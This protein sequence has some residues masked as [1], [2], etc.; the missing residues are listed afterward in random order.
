MSN[1]RTAVI[2]RVEI[3]LIQNGIFLCFKTQSQLLMPHQQDSSVSRRWPADST[4]FCCLAREKTSGRGSNTCLW[5][6]L[7]AQQCKWAQ[8]TQFITNFQKGGKAK[9]RSTTKVLQ[10]LT[11]WKLLISYYHFHTNINPKSNN[12]N[13]NEENKSQ[14]S[15]DCSTLAWREK[16]DR[17][18]WLFGSANTGF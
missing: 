2:W 8:N 7:W 5:R 4:G 12:V 14:S 16:L 10:P 1:K 17:E 15:G 6:A 11:S 13:T 3:A 18:A 9:S